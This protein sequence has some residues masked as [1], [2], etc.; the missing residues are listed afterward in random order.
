MRIAQLAPLAEGVPPKLYGGTERVVSWLTEE[1][2]RLGHH[3]TLFASGDSLT[4]AELVPVVPRAIRL[5]RPRPDPFPAYAAQLDAIARAGSS[6]DIVHCHTDWIHLPLLRSLGIPHLTTFH[7]RLDTPDLPA[8]MA[9]FADAPLISI[10]DNHRKPFPSANWLGTVYHGMPDNSLEPN[11][12]PGTYLAFLGRL[13]KE[14]GPETAIR[15]AKAAG[16]PLRMAAK[17]PRSEIRYY[18]TNLQPIID[19]DQIKLIG[20]VNDAGK[21]ELL[22]GA[23]ALLFP[24]DWPEPFGLVMIEAMACGT[25][26]IAFRRG[27]VPEVIDDG[28]TGYIVDSAE[29]AVAAIGRIHELDRRRVRATFEQ[30]FTAR[31][32]AGDYVRIYERLLRRQADQPCLNGAPILQGA[33]SASQPSLATE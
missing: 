15:L 33:T 1:L 19:G 27:S 14:K 12:E 22:R 21:G 32:M 11:F 25:P 13:T 30:R 3:V 17:I 26:V 23:A 10:S 2:V 9:R 8:V 5:N 16:M 18:K 29:E 28:V 20:E 24:I 31:R 6:F 7:N 4:R